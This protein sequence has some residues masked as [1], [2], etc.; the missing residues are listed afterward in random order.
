MN[1]RAFV[2]GLG[3][4][5][6]AP[7]AVKAQPAK[8]AVL[9]A[10]LVVKAQPAKAQ[11]APRMTQIAYVTLGTAI[12][13]AAFC[14]AFTDRLRD[15]GWWNS[16]IDYQPADESGPTYVV[17][18]AFV[19]DPVASASVPELPDTAWLSLPLPETSGKR[20]QLL[21]EVAPTVARVAVLSHASLPSIS[22]DVRET[23]AAAQKLGMPVH[24]VEVGRKSE[25]DEAFAA[26]A[27]ERATGVIVRP[28]MM[29]YLWRGHIARLAM[30][31]QLP[32]VTSVQAGCLMSYGPDLPDLAR[33][34]AY[35]M[36]KLFR[37]AAPADLQVEQP[38]QVEFTISVS[39][40]KALG[41]TIPPSLLLRANQVIE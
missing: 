29:L 35:F 4:V 7:L 24:V 1:R 5:L 25:L 11:R 31:H 32:A 28:S 13:N 12:P 23:E 17:G 38:M 20:V 16:L 21:R 14:E 8:G 27:Q 10:P 3:A 18:R 36:D 34:A 26:I 30:K 9:A 33:R 41:L 6:A 37:G 15:H 19:D 22:A 40:A 39:T 2:T